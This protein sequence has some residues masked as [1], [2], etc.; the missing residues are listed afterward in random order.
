MSEDEG[1]EEEEEDGEDIA[2]DRDNRWIRPGLLV[3]KFL[4]SRRRSLLSS[5][6]F[7]IPASSDTAP[8]R[9]IQRLNR[10]VDQSRDFVFVNGTDFP[11]KIPRSRNPELRGLFSCCKIDAAVDAVTGCADLFE[12]PK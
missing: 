7:R 6:I 10:H 11:H 2:A 3:V 5:E 12:G 9:L 8:D 1:E 4:V